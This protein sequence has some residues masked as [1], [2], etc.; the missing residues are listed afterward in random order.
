MSHSSGLVRLFINI[1][2]CLINTEE[3][4][5]RIKEAGFKI[6]L[7]KE[8]TLTKDVA[9]QFYREHEGKEFYDGLTDYMARY[10]YLLFNQ[11]VSFSDKLT[12]Q[13][14]IS[15]PVGICDGQAKHLSLPLCFYTLSNHAEFYIDF[16]R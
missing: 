12:G 6:Q 11:G 1:L 5:Q 2:F 3:V 16:P 10:V 9:S 15:A 7:E 8:V 4:I 14:P 13:M